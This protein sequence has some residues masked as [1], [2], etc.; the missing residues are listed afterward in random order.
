MCAVIEKWAKNLHFLRYRI[1]NTFSHILNTHPDA[2]WRN[3][4]RK[5]NQKINEAILESR[6]IEEQS[7]IKRKRKWKKNL[8]SIVSYGEFFDKH[9]CKYRC[10]QWYMEDTSLS[11]CT[12]GNMIWYSVSLHP[13]RND[14][15]S[16]ARW[17]NDVPT[18]E[19]YMLGHCVGEAHVIVP[20][21][22][23]I[24]NELRNT[25]Y[26]KITATC[27]WHWCNA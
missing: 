12:P 15:V 23:K 18:L 22:G 17:N 4:V 20:A 24:R 16:N 27:Q 14:P 7:Y 9:F 6:G 10:P 3:K 25:I 2:K 5:R 8:I 21:P 11:R 19:Q 26:T 13:G 1:S